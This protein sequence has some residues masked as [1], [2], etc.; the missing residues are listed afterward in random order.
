MIEN[1][2]E[3]YKTFKKLNPSFEKLPADIQRQFMD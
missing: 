2:S 1:E 3:E